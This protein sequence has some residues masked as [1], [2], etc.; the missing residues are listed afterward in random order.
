MII[1]KQKYEY[2]VK[3]NANRLL[4]LRTHEK[5]RI[6]GFLDDITSFSFRIITHFNYKC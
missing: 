6:F 4:E 2:W 5:Y 1:I 3:A